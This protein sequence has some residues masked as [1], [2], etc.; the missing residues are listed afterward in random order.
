MDTKTIGEHLVSLCREG[1]NLEA[2]EKLYSPDIVSVEPQS[3]PQMPAEMRGIDAIRGKNEW[4]YANHD[5]HSG[6]ADGPFV[7]GNRFSVV[8]D[9]DVTAKSGPQAGNRFQMK[10]IA[11]Y[12]VSDGKIVREEFFY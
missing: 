1:K 9:Y 6:H 5:V 8:F 11:V 4:W 12:T 2:V 10:E 3:M 7:H